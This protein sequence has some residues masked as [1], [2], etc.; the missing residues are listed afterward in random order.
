[1]SRTSLLI[2]ALVAVLGLAAGGAKGWRLS[3]AGEAGGPPGRA[4][5]G[6]GRG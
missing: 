1:M 5:G 2:I 4:P 3:R 6:G